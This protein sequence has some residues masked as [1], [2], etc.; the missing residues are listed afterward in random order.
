MGA[1]ISARRRKNFDPTDRLSPFQDEEG[2][3]RFDNVR[4][5]FESAKRGE[6]RMEN[7]EWRMRCSLR[8]LLD[9]DCIDCMSL[10]SI[11]STSVHCG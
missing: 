2:V 10:A 9:I 8:W 3:R 5:V 11:E 4:G 7:G 6:R 1:N